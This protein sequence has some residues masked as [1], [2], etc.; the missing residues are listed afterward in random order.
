MASPQDI[1]KMMYNNVHNSERGAKGHILVI[2][3]ILSDNNMSHQHN[4]QYLNFE[5]C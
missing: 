5:L 4:H 3:T 2:L 1:N